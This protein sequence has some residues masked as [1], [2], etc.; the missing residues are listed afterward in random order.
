MKL[1]LFTVFVC[2]SVVAGPIKGAKAGS[3]SGLRTDVSA[4]EPTATPSV[5]NVLT[6]ADEK[7]PSSKSSHAPAMKNVEVLEAR[8][9][10]SQSAFSSIP[11]GSPSGSHF[12][13]ATP[14]EVPSCG[15]KKS[16]D[17]D[18]AH[19]VNHTTGKKGGGKGGKKGAEERACDEESDDDKMSIHKS[20][21]G[22]SSAITIGSSLATAVVAL[23]YALVF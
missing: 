4:G 19:K 7:K 15:V 13:S 1:F 23:G 3:M 11:S 20:E 9:P 18:G 14:S 5:V 12:P 10:P 22:A 6:V 16:R 21:L 8:S 2:S 17:K